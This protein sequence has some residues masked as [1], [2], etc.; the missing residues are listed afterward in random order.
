MS[1]ALVLRAG[2]GAL[3]T[4]A[5]AKV[6]LSLHV[7][8][9]RA[10]GYHALE[11][12]VAFAGVADHLTLRPGAGLSLTIGG[13]R[14]DAIEASRGNL[15]LKAALALADQVPGLALGAFHLVKRLPV[16]AGIG[17][18]SA[19][20]GAALRLLA[21]RNGLP[22]EDPRLMA[23]ARATGADVPVCLAAAP[24]M[25]RGAGEKLGEPL[26]L[27]PLFAVL[28]NPGVA[29]ETA[30]VFRGLALTPGEARVG[31]AHPPIKTSLPP[32]TFTEVLA[33]GRND[34]EPPALAAAPVIGEALGLLRTI[35]DCRLA[36][37]SGSGATVFG[38]FD[39]CRAASRAARDLAALRPAWWVKA[40]V[41]R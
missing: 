24:R 9:R 39:D 16:A 20:A 34:L 6:N 37:M 22:L 14:A 10:D 23:A 4:R 8:G 7:L 32:A 2:D 31:A 19:D 38:L 36:R 15:V 27:P 17:G 25:M 35:P 12:L 3:V 11:S 40:T 5:P 33:A 13:L 1:R 41:L 18:G 21:E 28:V 30:T 26:S 29:V